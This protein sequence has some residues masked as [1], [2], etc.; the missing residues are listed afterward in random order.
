MLGNRD[1][2]ILFCGKLNKGLRS[3]GAAEWNELCSAA[4]R[5]GIALEQL[6]FFS[7][8]DFT[9]KLK[10]DA[11]FSARLSRLNNGSGEINEKLHAYASVGIKAVTVFDCEYPAR[12]TGKLGKSRPPV[13][14]CAGDM[15]LLNEKVIGF[16]GSRNAN[17]DDLE[18]SRFCVE[19][20]ASH[21]YGV[22]SGGARGV[23]WECEL[24][25]LR[26]GKCVVEF[27]ADNLLKRLNQPEISNAVNSGKMAL[28]SLAAPDE[29]FNL[30]IAMMRNRY[31]YA[32]SDGTVVI[33]SDYNKGG[34]WAGATDTL[35]RG[36]CKLLCSRKSVY[37]GNTAL[38]ERGAIPIDYTF[39]GNVGAIERPLPPQQLSLF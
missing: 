36:W 27:P 24:Q 11:E 1:A 15:G 35:K 37:A 33:R 39:D 18:F 12:L 34:T 13:F 8:K 30:G 20:T 16:V 3:L 7:E 17:K 10:L 21:G 4:E 9:D 2:A 29:G 31:I 38:I 23:D 32:Q 5:E 26:L 25:A 6:L 22:V 19:R 28:V 14:Y